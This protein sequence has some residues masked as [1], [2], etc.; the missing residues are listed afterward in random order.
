MK[1][2]DLTAAVWKNELNVNTLT[3]MDILCDEHGNNLTLGTVKYY[4]RYMGHVDKSDCETDTPLADGLGNDQK[5]S[6]LDL[7]ILNS[8]ILTSCG[9]KGSH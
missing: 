3:N 6:P 4:N 5:S 1:Q 9:L 7:S 2:G 8:F